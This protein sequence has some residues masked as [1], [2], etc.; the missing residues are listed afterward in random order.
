MNVDMNSSFNSQ[1]HLNQEDMTPITRPGPNGKAALYVPS[2]EITKELAQ[3]IRPGAAMVGYLNH[4]NLITVYFEANRFNDPGLASWQQKTCKAYERLV[5]NLP[6][7]SKI[8]TSP[9]NLKQIGYMNG[10]G[11]TIR[12][13]DR[14]RDWLAASDALDSGPETSYTPPNKTTPLTTRAR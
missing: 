9:T 1:N 3:L 12:H 14:L 8:S 13:M 6:T 5:N 4:D 11:I 10:D 7:V 2:D